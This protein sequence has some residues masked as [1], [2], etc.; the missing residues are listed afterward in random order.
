VHNKIEI[1]AVI[2]RV[3]K[4]LKTVQDLIE[5]KILFAY[6]WTYEL[7]D[8]I[9]DDCHFV[10]LP[11]VSVNENISAKSPNRL[12]DGIQRGKLVLT[13][14]GVDSYIPFRNF[15]YFVSDF[16]YGQGLKFAINNRNEALRNIKLGQIYI[17]QHH[18]P[19]IIGKQWI[20]IERL[21]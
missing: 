4:H 10:L 19:E 16:N 11:I 14:A 13:N 2:G 7:Q 1:H 6:Q 5:K 20:E 9:V 15:S 12:I 8:Q 17:D 18:T 3:E 21:V